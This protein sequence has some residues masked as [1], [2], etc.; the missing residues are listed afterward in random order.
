MVT[1]ELL[2]MVGEALL[3]THRDTQSQACEIESSSS[4]SSSLEHIP[5]RH[6]GCSYK[7][8]KHIGFSIVMS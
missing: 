2:G 8:N 3:G 6:G 1:L 4:S 5:E 7:K